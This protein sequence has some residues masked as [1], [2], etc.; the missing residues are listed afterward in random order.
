MAT[1]N[2]VKEYANI[3]KYKVRLIQTNSHQAI[4]IREY[5]ENEQFTGFTRRG[6]RIIVG[7]DTIALQNILSELA[8]KG[9]KK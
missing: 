2:V 7:A 9:G 4:D 1:D 8:K 5:V 3:G 6:V